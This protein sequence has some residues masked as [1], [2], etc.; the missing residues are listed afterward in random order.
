MLNHLHAYLNRVV[1]VLRR[2]EGQSLAEYGMLISVIAIVVLTAAALLGS[3]ISSMF[4]AVVG[5]I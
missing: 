5:K 1:A 4:S 2:S 3:N